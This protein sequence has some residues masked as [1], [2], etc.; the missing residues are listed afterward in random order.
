M[1]TLA[2]RLRKT[3]SDFL[4]R[5]DALWLRVACSETDAAIVFKLLLELERKNRGDIFLLFSTRFTDPGQYVTELGRL[6]IAECQALDSA[7][8]VQPGPPLERLPERFLGSPSQQLAVLLRTARALLPED[9]DQR[10]IVA[11]WPLELAAPLEYEQLLDS[12]LP[13]PGDATTDGGSAAL[14]P[15][16]RRV[17]LI[18]RAAKDMPARHRSSALKP[19]LLR[20]ESDSS[21]QA[22]PRCMQERVDAPQSPAA[23]R[24]RTL[25]MLAALEAA[26]GDGEAARTSYEQVLRDFES[27]PSSMMQTIALL[28]LGALYQ[29]QR[30]L[31]AARGC[32]ERALGAAAITTSPICVAIIAKGLGEI[33]F[34]EQRYG[35]ATAAYQAYF[36]LA[37][38]LG[39]HAGAEHAQQRLALVKSGQ[40]A[41]ANV[42]PSWPKETTR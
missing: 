19:Y 12:L 24:M 35:D 31:S 42:A 30:Q 8:A 23:S 41:N 25:I 39:D 21:P 26:Y 33:A 37:D 18:G 7:L 29:R 17:R 32:Y 13:L 20:A 40:R 22:L 2:L 16:L 3:I 15:W 36:H 28:Q 1:R 4:D 6:F 38:Q 34:L 10:L 9:G 27:Q 11:F 5:R 14:P